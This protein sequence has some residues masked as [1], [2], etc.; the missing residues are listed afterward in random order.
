MREA[1]KFK[2]SHSEKQGEN[3]YVDSKRMEQRNAADQS[4]NSN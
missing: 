4:R 1:L 2:A 3:N